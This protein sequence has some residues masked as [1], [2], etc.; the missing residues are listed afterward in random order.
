MFFIMGITDGRKDFDFQQQMI[1]AVCGRYGRYQ[2]FMTYTVLTLFF[3]PCFRWNRHYYVQTS[4]CDTM[5]EL[6]PA[7]GKRIARGEEVKIQPQDLE[8]VQSRG[9]RY[10]YK[11][12]GGCGFETTEDFAFCPK[13][14]RR[15]WD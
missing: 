1:C 4:C 13:C 9:R 7:V 14:G 6:D 2:V 12:C 3:I 10:A 15:F 5:Y 11:R 8:R